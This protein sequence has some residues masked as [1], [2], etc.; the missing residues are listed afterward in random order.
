MIYVAYSQR[1]MSIREAVSGDWSERISYAELLAFSD[2]QL[3]E[4]MRA[5]NA[6]AFAVVFKRYHRLVHLVA[7]QVLRDAGEAEDITQTVFLQIYRTLGQFDVAKGSLKGWLLLHAQR[8]S[9]NR[10]NYLLVRQFHNR[11]ELSAVDQENG[12]WSPRRSPVQETTQVTNE[13]LSALPE[14]QRQTI[15]MYFLEGLSMKE[16]AERRE[17]SFSNVRHHYYRGL[18]RLR[19]YLEK[20]IPH[21]AGDSA[22][23]PSGEA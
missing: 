9:L 7:L 20:G 14:A 10:R 2:E 23:V 15:Q 16:I 18:E 17:E 13:V 3:I 5:G 21:E 4:E 1:S 8:R 11:V 19:F 6:D 22:V 12:L